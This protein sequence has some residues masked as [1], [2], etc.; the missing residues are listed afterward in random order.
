MTRNRNRNRIQIKCQN[1]NRKRLQIFRFRNPADKHNLL[2]RCLHSYHQRVPCEKI[3]G[4][5]QV[6]KSLWMV[7][8][9]QPSSSLRLSLGGKPPRSHRMQAGGAEGCAWKIRHWGQLGRQRYIV[10]SMNAGSVIPMESFSV[11][12]TVPAHGT[13]IPRG[14]LS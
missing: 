14:L 3:S 8:I 13:C 11:A 12:A 9:W 1:R 4:E 7:L 10:R 5:V 6:G 2:L